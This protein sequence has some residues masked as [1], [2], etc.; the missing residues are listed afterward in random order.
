MLRISDHWVL[1][2]FSGV[3]NWILKAHYVIKDLEYCKVFQNLLMG[4]IMSLLFMLMI[5][6]LLPLQLLLIP[7]ENGVTFPY[8]Y[9]YLFV[10]AIYV[11]CS[12]LLVR[13]KIFR[14]VSKGSGITPKF[15]CTEM[16]HKYIKQIGRRQSGRCI[17]FILKDKKFCNI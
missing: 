14:N 1:Y 5:Y 13:K 10:Q 7:P 6:L 9:W 15:F 12:A 2:L 16:R 17:L 11:L 4:I 3:C 8:C